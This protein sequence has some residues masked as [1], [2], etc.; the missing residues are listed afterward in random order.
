MYIYI[1]YVSFACIACNSFNL[2]PDDFGRA[3]AQVLVGVLVR[4]EPVDMG[5]WMQHIWIVIHDLVI[6]LYLVT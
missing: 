2:V 4:R 1:Y 5:W 6:Q 3:L